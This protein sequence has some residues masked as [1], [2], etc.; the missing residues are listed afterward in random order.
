MKFT[1]LAVVILVVTNCTNE[2]FTAP[3]PDVGFVEEPAVERISTEELL[4]IT[5]ERTFNYFWDF[6]EENSGLAR[7]TSRDDAIGGDGNRVVTTGGSGF[8]IAAFPAAVE[9]GWITRA[10]AIERLDKILNFLESCETYHGAFSHWYLGDTG[11]TRDFSELDDGAD[12]VETAFLLQGL[13][14]NKQY[15]DSDDDAEADI[16]SRISTIYDNVEWSWFE[17]GQNSMTWHWSPENE[18]AI[19][20]QIQ[21]WNESLMVYVL[22]A[23]SNTFPITKETYDN[24]WSR[25]G[26]MVNGNTYVGTRLPLG[27]DFGGP[28]FYAHYSFI[29]LDPRNLS[30]QYAN[31]ME[32]NT[33]H[34]LINYEYCRNNPNEY[35]GY[36]G[37]SWGLTAS[38]DFNG[39]AVHDPL[40]DIGV[41]TPTAAL[42]S[43][44]YTPEESQKALEYFYYNLNDRLW[45][46]YGFYD[47]FSE[48]FNWYDDSYLAIDQGPIVGMIENYRTQLLWNLFMQDEQVQNG[49]DL[50]GF[51]Y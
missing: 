14:I 43:F 37:D 34:S 40:N 48:E 3:P 50:L 26:Q 1:T 32:Q 4:D 13:L 17:R 10:E 25:N 12:I 6:A 27:V 9:R 39:Y 31:Y 21:G 38:N 46:E 41:I 8:G 7:E 19:D 36:G 5:Q 47:A 16:R 23:G 2:D 24:G 18:F 20:L 30:D 42:S 22:A 44:P 35:L 49:L 51:T 29:G 33:A 28:L 45:G 11:V 15:F